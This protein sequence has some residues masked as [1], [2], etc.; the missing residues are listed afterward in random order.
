MVPNEGE[1]VP[2]I[3]TSF[4]KPKSA[5]VPPVNWVELTVKKLLL[6][7]QILMPMYVYV[8][9]SL[10]KTREV[11]VLYQQC[12]STLKEEAVRLGL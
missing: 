2:A 12:A 5:Q 1:L 10:M 7:L 6:A 4:V 9:T 3:K 8:V 11:K